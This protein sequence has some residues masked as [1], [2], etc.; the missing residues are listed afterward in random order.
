MFGFISSKNLIPVLERVR[1]WVT[2]RKP[3]SFTKCVGK[4]PAEN[5]KL[6]TM[7]QRREVTILVV[8]VGQNGHF[9]PRQI[10]YP[11]AKPCSTTWVTTT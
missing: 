2:K 1:E 5:A 11:A 3:K 4:L 8:V 10:G 7:P 9:V 6:R